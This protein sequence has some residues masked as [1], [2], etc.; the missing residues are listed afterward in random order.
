MKIIKMHSP[1]SE[2][3]DGYVRDELNAV[4]VGSG[5]A[6]KYMAGMSFPVPVEGAGAAAP[7]QSF[8]Q[9]HRK[10]F[11]LLGLAAVFVGAGLVFMNQRNDADSEAPAVTTAPAGN[12][13][14]VSDS[15]N[16]NGALENNTAT[17]AENKGTAQTDNGTAGDGTTDADDATGRAVIDMKAP[18]AEGISKIS[19]NKH[20]R[21]AAD[22]GVS[23]TATI[24]GG[25]AG[26]NPGT[27]S[28][29]VQLATG[30]APKP[31]SQL[32]S[33][34]KKMNAQKPVVKKDTVDVIW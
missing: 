7:Q 19:K 1:H 6:D 16:K 34:S 5:L 29:D 27:S 26:V 21:T 32:D 22:D 17:P 8:F 15:Q 3:F 24:D 2:Q 11:W 9:K 33:A 23:K 31:A 12:T 30:K 13:G 28:S 14:T 18:P 4:D 20:N 25:K 10:K